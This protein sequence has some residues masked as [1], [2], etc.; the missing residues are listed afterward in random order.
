M[1][2][3]NT[4]V[5]RGRHGATWPSVAVVVAVGLGVS[6]GPARAS[7]HAPCPETPYPIL[8]AGTH[9]EHP[10]GD[11]E[12][13]AFFLISD[14]SSWDSFWD[15]HDP[16]GTPPAVDFAGGEDVVAV[17]AGARP[18]S[19]YSIDIVHAEEVANALD[20]ATCECEPGPG[21]F[22]EQI[23]TQPFQFV[24]IQTSATSTGSWSKSAFEA[25][26]ASVPSSGPSAIALVALLLAAMSVRSLRGDR[27]SR[28]QPRL[29]SREPELAREAVRHRIQS[30]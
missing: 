8:D 16:G 18:S 5:L 26:C 12:D 24:R 10:A 4:R 1:R 2:R 9:S 27:T 15:E 28:S 25:V 22:T 20:L 3:G 19:G 29:G 21:C 6:P 14:Q 17:F 11:T 30:R 23:E 13:G 7:Q